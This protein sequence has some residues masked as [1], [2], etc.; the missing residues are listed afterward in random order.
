MQEKRL[1]LRITGASENNLKEVSLE[2]DHDELTVVTGL[3]GSGKSSLAFSTVYA[4]GQRRYIETFSAYTRQFLDRLKKPSVVAVE[5]VRPAIAIQQKTR[6][7]SSRS[8]VGSMTNVNDL[9]KILWANLSEPVSPIT[10]EK[11]VSF[12]P[13]DIVEHLLAWEK[14]LE[15]DDGTPHTV[16]IAAP[17]PLPKT[18]KGRQQELDRLSLL[19]FS[20]F[21]DEESRSVQKLQ[22][23]DSPKRLPEELLLVL[24]RI[25][26][27][28]I[29]RKELLEHLTQAYELSR[30]EAVLLFPEDPPPSS[31]PRIF[32]GKARFSQRYQTFAY[33]QD[34]LP[35]KIP[36]RRAPLFDPN[37][38]VGACPT[39]TGFG[40]VLEIDLEKV[41]PN[42]ALS[43]EAGAIL[44]W[45][46]SSD[47]SLQKKLLLFSEKEGISTSSPW[48]NLSEEDRKKILSVKERGYTGVFPWFRRLEQKRHRMHVRVLLSRYRSQFLCPACHGGR[49]RPEALCFHLGGSSLPQIWETPIAELLGWLDTVQRSL[50]TGISTSRD[51]QEVLERLRARVRYLLDLGL[52]YM[53]L[54]RPSRTLSGGETQRVNLTTALGSELVSTH[55]VL[56]E[57]SVGLHP[58]DTERLISSMRTLQSKGNSVLVVEHDTD[59]IEAAD[60]VVE[61]GPAAGS[62]GGEVVF[63]D[64]QE[65]WPGIVEREKIPIPRK[66]PKKQKKHLSIRGATARNLKNLSVQIPVGLFT[67]VTGVSG[68]GKSTLL[69]EVILPAW[70][71]FEQRGTCE[72]VDGFEHF[73]QT[74]L[75]DQ[76]GLTKSPRAN[77]ATYTG[78]WDTFRT[79]L[80]ETD[81]AE[82]R[83]LTKSSFSFNVEGGRCPVCKG[84]GYLKEDMQ[85]LSDVY[86]QC[87]DCLGKRFQQ[88]VLEVSYEGRNVA[89]WLECTVADLP[90][91]LEHHRNIAGVANYLTQLGLGHLRLG[92]SLSELSGGE[93]QRLK[94]IPFLERAERHSHSLLLFD[95]PTTGLHL[96]DVR[97]LIELFRQLTVQGHTVLAIEHNQEFLLGSDYL[98]DLGP[99]GG[100]G[101]GELILQGTPNDFLEHQKKTRA[102]N[103]THSSYT[104]R[105]LAEYVAAS[106]KKQRGRGRSDTA[107]P[108]TTAPK[109]IEDTP[110]RV[111]GAREHNLKDVT[112]ELP[113]NS[114]IAVTGV[115]GSGKSTVAKDIIYAEGQRRYL[116]CLSPYARQFIRE[117]SKPD[118]EEVQ[119]IRPTVCVYQH[120]FQPGKRSTL[121]TMSEVYNFLRLLYSKAGTQYCPDHPTQRV[122]ALSAQDIASSL[123]SDPDETVKLLAPIIKGRKGSHKE[124]F[125][126]ALKSEIHEVRVD[127]VF[128]PTGS[129]LDGLERNKQH[130]IDYVWA[131]IIPS[132][133]PFELVESAIEEVFAISGGTVV[134]HSPSGERIY[135]RE[136]A[137]PT[138]LRGFFRPD[139]EDL[140]FHSRRGR[141]ERCD[142]LGWREHRQH[143]L[144]RC[145]SC[146]G[147]R[148]R[149]AGQSVRLKEKNIAEL[150]DLT[151]PEIETFLHD[152][153]W[154]DRLAVITAPILQEITARLQVLQRV[155]LDYLPLSRSCETLSS[156]ELQRLR[157]AAALGTPLNGALYIFDEPSAGLHP[158]DNEQILQEFTALKDRENTVLLIEH[159]E[160]TILHSEHVLEIGPEGGRKGGEITF[161]GPIAE[162][163]EREESFTEPSTYSSRPKKKGEMM[164]LAVSALNNIRSLNTEIPTEQFVTI[165]GVSGAGKSSLVHEALLPLVM[166]ACEEGQLTAE[167]ECAA[168]TLPEEFERV[169][170]IDQSPI[171][172]NSRSTPASYLKIFDEIRKLFASTVEAKAR[173]WT[174]SFFSYNSGKGRCPECRGLGRTQLEMSFLSE[175][176]VTC[177]HCRGERYGD[178]A[179]SIHYQGHTIADVLRMTFEEAKEVFSAHQKIHRIV[180][181]TCELGLGYLALGQSSTTLSGGESQRMKLVTELAKPQR[182]KTLYVLDEPTIG[183]HRSDVARLLKVLHSLTALENTVLV[184]EHDRDVIEQSD[185]VIELGPGPG[186]AGGKVIFSGTP[187][188]LARKRTPWGKR[189]GKA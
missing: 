166:E 56:D 120:T 147:S 141:C 184:I 80:A 128:L 182:G 38:N 77:I 99:E 138:C 115:S 111:I 9:L 122:E 109:K 50:A 43:L 17:L 144:Q 94:L 83:S 58:R 173:G 189:L 146:N 108:S 156:G 139:P 48:E 8:T 66:L 180:H 133:V 123:R 188:Q 72:H 142:G 52:P 5:N 118:I 88:K 104:A 28:K 93:A 39:C 145:S 152:I 124:V 26:S 71:S 155:G 176:H 45:E 32:D 134:I 35:F 185:Y 101:G 131:T 70:K 55:F 102:P 117:L 18:V 53:T 11:L 158:D 162:Y 106:Q 167:N 21:F 169:L 129:L 27:G 79:A 24:T 84:A 140:S 96:H 151:A 25:K 81:E 31:F 121:G 65:A 59:C 178:E 57:P 37:S 154:S 61:L 16:L 75:I 19:G 62:A 179:L 76:S 78:I 186:E 3:S 171:G 23:I 49:L 174:Q 168:L 103:D 82:K 30:G 89:E 42:S 149:P 125:R 33:S 107:S 2:L 41:V 90:N 15:G 165:A 4:E 87:E 143:G 95:E 136:R 85:F 150:C 126:R 112:V 22:E 130:D 74:L 113:H 36:A 119:N 187:R 54:G 7:V 73:S 63:N 172:K 69:T 157:L 91:L 64:R 183:L 100:A 86:V 116:D 34:P 148:I 44:P 110:L 13:A 10:G 164:T 40:H 46:S 20:R 135:S 12:S 132:R 159:D 92:H 137:C 175:A 60:R 6:V 170:V 163:K 67:T 160:E 114:V 29:R 127:G 1:P 68:S 177:D 14:E 105:Y 51:I 153:P 47:S 98:I 181:T 161:N 97:N